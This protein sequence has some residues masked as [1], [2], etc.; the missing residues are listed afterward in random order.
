MPFNQTKKYPDLLEFTG[1]NKRQTIE[2]LRGIFD[3]DIADNDKFFFRGKRIY[4]IKSDGLIDLE[5]EFSHLTTEI[6]KEKD[7][8]GKEIE[9]RRFDKFRS[10]RLHWIRPHTEE[11]VKDSNIVTFSIRERDCK[12]RMDINRTYIYNKTRKYVVVFEPQKRSMYDGWYLLTAYYL[13]R[14]YG[15][16]VLNKKLKSPDC[17]II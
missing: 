4:P 1:Y 17:A 3:R 8:Q 9:H 11:R 7:E 10:E 16:K 13:N 2:S 6:V 14:E 15:E 5:R 12:K